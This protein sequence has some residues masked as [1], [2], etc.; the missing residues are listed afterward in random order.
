MGV[1]SLLFTA[2][3]SISATSACSS[4][5]GDQ[6]SSG[7]PRF[8][9]RM[10]PG[11]VTAE[12]G[13]KAPL[14]WGQI[15]FIHTTDSH[16][17]LE[18]HIKERN[19]G[20][21]WGDFQS[22]VEHMRKRAD[23]LDVDLLVID[24]GDLHDGNGLS[25]ATTP[26]GEYSNTIFKRID[27]D[28][29]APG[30][31]ELYSSVVVNQTYQQFTKVYTDRY[32]ASNINTTIT[33]ENVRL[34]APYRY[35][36]TKRGMRI[37]AFGVMFDW[38]PSAKVHATIQPAS[39]MIQ[40]KWFQDA[41]DYQPID[42]FV[43]IGHNPV[44]QDEYNTSSFGLVQGA[45]RKR[46]PDVPIQGFGGHTH[47]RDFKCFSERSSAL[48]SGKYCDTVG[49]LALGNIESSTYNGTRTPSGVPAPRKTC[50]ASLN[51]DEEAGFA[52]DDHQMVMT[53]PTTIPVLDRRYLD[54]NRLTFAYHATG[55]Q[56]IFDTLEGLNTTAD[57]TAERE[58]LNITHRYGCAPKTYCLS[59]K[60]VGHE[61][62]I[63]TLLQKVMSAIVINE[64]RADQARIIIF[65]NQTVRYDLVQGPFTLD[66]SYIVIPY[67]D[68][69]KY[70]PDVPFA[71]ASRLLNELNKPSM[72]NERR[73]LGD[74]A[75]SRS[76]N[77]A[78][79]LDP[80]DPEWAA[81]M[82]PQT[83]L[84]Q[85]RTL[86]R[87]VLPHDAL[88]PGYKTAD[89]LG[90]AGDGDDTPH[91]AYDPIENPHYI[92]ANAG[93]LARNDPRTVDVVFS[94]HLSKAI[95]P[96]LKRL[97]FKDT[98]AFDYTP[99]N[100]TTRTVIPENDSKNKA[101]LA[102]IEYIM[103]SV[104]LHRQ[105]HASILGSRA[106]S[107][108]TCLVQPPSA[109]APIMTAA[110]ASPGCS[111]SGSL[112]CTSLGWRDLDEPGTFFSHRDVDRWH[113]HVYAEAG[114]A[115]LP[116]NEIVSRCIGKTVYGD[117]AVDG[118]SNTQPNDY[119]EEFT[120]VELLRT[121]SHYIGKNA[122]AENKRR[123]S[124]RVAGLFGMP[125]GFM[126]EHKTFTMP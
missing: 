103:I 87:R 75:A 92:Q 3:L 125:P 118:S 49:W 71:Y 90:T 102:I 83:G 17:W 10:Q 36:T 65:N 23:S 95:P 88:V 45:I 72:S 78:S 70:I 35:F 59:C 84:Y 124:A 2:F 126:P 31:H 101:N 120:E 24:T 21:D 114:D 37:M 63:Y 48:E 91:A 122:A 109:P 5:G 82:D 44:R 57:I 16:G 81:A 14:P 51:D 38:K 64:T 123:E 19:F 33:G 6:G 80:S 61:R 98:G 1:L 26:N 86:F 40:E 69:F 68:T 18:G 116:K 54:W 29:L 74:P 28:L 27:Y 22:F 111:S 13:P 60:P 42:L 56:D 97:G 108:Q 4:C 12:T 107:P 58:N 32:L 110:C 117:V 39:Q 46:R 100:I 9:R 62:N 76:I 7:Y 106:I 96:V 85:R 115:S 94:S 89:D 112:R 34:G 11:D 119:S 79:C 93:F 113:Y 77:P 66:D 15:N 67:E 8:T 73:S 43:L 41:V 99:A 20:A 47:I 25:D 53:A 105:L 104:G 52:G 121:T 55:S 50:H 30:N